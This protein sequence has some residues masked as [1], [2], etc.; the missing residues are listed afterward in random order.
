MFIY[1]RILKATLLMALVVC[2]LVPVSCGSGGESPPA[3]T[4]AAG[5]AQ[6][7]P[8]VPADT[9]R[10][11][12]LDGI[13]KADEL[14]AGWKEDAELYALASATPQVDADG[15]APSWLYTYVSPSAGAVASVSIT[16][17]KAKLL[18]EQALPD[19]QIRDISNNTLPPPG[20][21]LD[22]PK[23]ME[24][25]TKVRKVL[26]SDP[27]TQTAAGLDS[28]SSEQPVWFVSTT[29]SGERVEERITATKTG[30]S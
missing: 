3:E 23:A 14:A 8:T 28:F 10:V 24:K 4:T 16:G 12:A 25:A 2:A 13:E 17:E 18:P 7:A 21:L 20:K 11:A 27:G 30:G 22:S 9:A 15:R 19:D 29:Q 1:R 6:K 5:N 26:E